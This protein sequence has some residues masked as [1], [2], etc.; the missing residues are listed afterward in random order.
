MV[1]F[2]VSLVDKLIAKNILVFNMF[3]R[4]PENF[5]YG[6]SFIGGFPG[7]WISFS[8][9]NHKIG[10]RKQAFRNR[11]I[12]AALLAPVVQYVVSLM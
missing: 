9:L 1:A 3:Q 4:V 6:I 2:G 5:F 10:K 7:L 8:L 12:A 11:V